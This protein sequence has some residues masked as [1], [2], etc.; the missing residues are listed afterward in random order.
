MGILKM[1]LSGKRIDNLVAEQLR[2]CEFWNP[3]SQDEGGRARVTVVDPFWTH[4]VKSKHGYP[5]RL[6]K[7]SKEVSPED[8]DCAIIP[9]GYAPD[10]LRRC[11]STLSLVRSMT[12]SGCVIAA[13]CHAG[14]VLISSEVISGRKAKHSFFSIK[15]RT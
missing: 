2:E 13:I 11:Q 12:E 3:F 4:E 10:L 1:E 14:W 6:E 9:G 7:R 15:E 8:F 5:V